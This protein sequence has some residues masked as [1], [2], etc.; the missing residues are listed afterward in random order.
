MRRIA[1]A[2]VLM[3]C[4][5]LPAAEPGKTYRFA[6]SDAGQLP[7]GWKAAKTGEGTGSVWKVVADPTAPSKSGY[8][9]AQTAEGP[10]PFFNLCV[11]EDSR[12]K[13]GTV[14]VRLKAVRGKLDQG[15]GV[16]WRYKDADNYYVCRY[17]P[18]EDNFR[19]Y[20]VVAGKRIQLGTKEGLKE[21]P[22]QWHTVSARMA[23]DRIECSLD[24][25]KHLEGKVRVGSRSSHFDPRTG[26]VL[27]GCVASRCVPDNH[28]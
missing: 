12:F 25:T 2:A 4:L 9:L 8:A 19:V 18:L 27:A 21:T 5:P 3:A 22:G 7:A 23:G 15:G 1:T 28:R 14:S 26:G 17:N 10:N 13:D 11:A 16:V 6:A 24:G 20:K